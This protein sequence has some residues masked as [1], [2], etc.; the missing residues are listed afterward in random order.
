[1]TVPFVYPSISPPHELDLPGIHQNHLVFEIASTKISVA[2]TSVN[3]SMTVA[4]C[5]FS[6]IELT[7][8]QPSSSSALIVGARLPGVIFVASGSLARWTLYWQ[9]TYFWAAI[10]H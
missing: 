10:W 6:T 4:I 7:A 8:T 2:P 1:L 5:F 3:A 9:S